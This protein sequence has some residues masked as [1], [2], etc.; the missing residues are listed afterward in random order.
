MGPIKFIS[1][2]VFLFLGFSVSMYAQTGEDL[3][4]Q[5]CTACHKIGEGKFL[6]PDLQGVNDRRSKEWLVKFIQSSQTVIKAGDPD[7][8]ALFNQFNKI[9]MPDMPFTPDQVSGILS[10]IGS[11][12]PATQGTATAKQEAPPEIEFTQEEALR[13]RDLFTGKAS[14]ENQGPSCLSCHLV[15]DREI[16]GGGLLAKDLTDA[17]QRL[18]GGNAIISILSSRPFPAMGIAYQNKA[19][20]ESEIKDLAAYLKT[21]N[22]N[23]VAT[24]QKAISTNQVFWVGGFGGLFFLLIIIHL[25]WMRRRTKTVKS[26]I[27]NRQLTTH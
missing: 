22:E 2:V 8:V 7:A 20:T 9:A 5:N 10:Y 21:V 1:S 14:M 15:N 27:F 26:E 18:G 12:G 4:K 23:F 24:P 25:L 16:T 19:L 13:G 6:G 11:F 17:F 3:F